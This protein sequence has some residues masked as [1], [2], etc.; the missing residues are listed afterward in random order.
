MSIETLEAKVDQILEVVTG[1]ADPKPGVLPFIPG[2]A[3]AQEAAKAAAAAEAARLAELA[4]QIDYSIYK[5]EGDA[6]CTVIAQL[7][8]GPKTFAEMIKQYPEE[9]ARNPVA[10]AFAK[11]YPSFFADCPGC[12]A[13]VLAG[14][15]GGGCPNCP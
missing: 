12:L 8:G 5:C 10:V 6:F 1:L 13:V 4:K 14:Q 15:G 3:A 2:Q 9:S 7:A 11:K